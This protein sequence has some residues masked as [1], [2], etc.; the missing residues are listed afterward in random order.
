MVKH[1]ETAFAEKMQTPFLMLFFDVHWMDANAHPLAH[2]AALGNNTN[3][4]E[5]GHLHVPRRS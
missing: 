1:R 5:P 4:C 2:C 3:P